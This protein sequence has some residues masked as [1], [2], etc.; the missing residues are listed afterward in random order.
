M[1][2][3]LKLVLASVLLVCVL[4][5]LAVT[6][7]SSSGGAKPQDQTAL[8]QPEFAEELPR[9]A[10]LIT[11]PFF[12]PAVQEVLPSAGPE[13]TGA[14]QPIPGPTSPVTPVISGPMI[15]YPNSPSNPGQPP[16][17]PGSIPSPN[18]SQAAQKEPEPPVKVTL[19]GLVVGGNPAAFLRINDAPS[20]KAVTGSPLA[21]GITVIDVSDKHV[22]LS[23]K[24]KVLKL[25]PGQAENL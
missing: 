18:P 9:V 24:G 3:N 22:T 17:L 25:K 8:S 23:R 7:L 6:L 15:A 16:A 5:Y 4:A 11:D 10:T 13:L 19:Q 21:H 2:Q 12:H 1:K 20:E 14:L